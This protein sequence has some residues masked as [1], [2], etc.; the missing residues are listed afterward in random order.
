M[1]FMINPARLILIVLAIFLS[2]C[3]Q[4]FMR[5]MAANGMV[6]FGNEYIQP[7]FM[8][9][10]DTD[11]LCAMGEGMTAMAFPMGPNVD[12]MIPMLTLASGMCAE[13]RAREQELRYIRAMRQNN[14]EEAQDARTL[15]KRWRSLAAKRMYTGYQAGVRHFGVP[16]GECP[17]FKDDH[18]ELAYMFALFV[19][20]QAAQLDMA[21]GAK[22]GVPLDIIPKSIKG[23]SCLPSDKYWGIPD[24]V[25]AVMAIMKANVSG[26]KETMQAHIKNLEIASLVGKS[27]GV[28]M[29]QMLEA[30]LYDNLGDKEKVKA[31]IR[32]HVETKKRVAANPELKIIDEMATRGILLISDKMWTEATGQ[33][34]PFGKLGT[35]W[36]DPVISEDTPDIDDLL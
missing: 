18:E 34:T 35:F 36:D 2:G 8:A 20:L 5:D 12:Q 26:D 1:R 7:W 32:D 27:Q 22:V 19:G 25:E 9:S 33:R 23:L 17:M 13:E 24:A 6:S 3:S 10:D 21:T 29:V 16:G 28:R 14:V 30:A 15:Q 31:I 4:H 11:V